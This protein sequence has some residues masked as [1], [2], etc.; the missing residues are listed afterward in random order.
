MKTRKA[1]ALRKRYRYRR[2]IMTGRLSLPHP[3]A[4][5]LIGPDCA[6]HLYGFMGRGGNKTDRKRERHEHRTGGVD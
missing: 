5:R 4:R 3:T 6:Y 2:L 1:E